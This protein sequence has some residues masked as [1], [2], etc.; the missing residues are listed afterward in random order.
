MDNTPRSLADTLKQLPPEWPDDLFPDIQAAVR[1]R[2]EKVVVL[3]DDPT[4]TQTVHAIP[5]LTE[6]PVEAL[7]AELANDL[8]AFYLLTNSRSMP[9]DAARALN[10]EIGRNLATAADQTGRRYVV[11]SRSD[12]TLRGH[13]PGEVDALAEALGGRFHATLLIPA[14][15]EGGRYTIEDVHY[16]ADG[17]RLIPAGATEFARDAAFGYQASNL[18]AWVAE[19]TGGRFPFESIAAISL[20]DLRRG[21]PRRVTE[22]LLEIP[23]GGVCVVNAA[24]NHDLMVLVAGLLE[25]EA[26]GRQFMHRTAASFVP[27]R[28]GISPRPLLTRDDL[29]LPESGGGLV[30]VGSYVPKTSAQLASLLDRSGI[31]GVEVSVTALLSDGGLGEITRVARVAEEAL[32]RDEDVVIYT[33]RQLVTGADAE[34]SLAIG[35]RVS[36]SLIAIVR[37]ITVRPRYLLAKGGITSSDVA[38]KGL[39][40]RRA[41]VQGQILPGVPVWQLG[42]ESRRP[43]MTYIVFPGNVGGPGALREIVASLAPGR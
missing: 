18:R 43:G 15:F 5:V 19:K 33:S 25:A 24:G 6:W 38:T 10:V 32:R 29:G 17:D 16:V 2:R 4:G 13:Y 3:D 34:S 26:R 27:L 28:A 39:G 20:Q 42:L 40:V 1:A 9:L 41:M 23:T 7:C 12:S 30:V 35:Q 37:Q 8:P 14:F 11:V 22:R 21:G 36:N 31:R